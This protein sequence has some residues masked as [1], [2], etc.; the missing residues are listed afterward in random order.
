MASTADVSGALSWLSEVPRNSEGRME[1]TW[2]IEG[3]GSCGFLLWTTSL[4]LLRELEVRHATDGFW[5]GKKVL[6]LG[7]GMG[8]MAVGLARMG[9]HVTATEG[10][11]SGKLTAWTTKLLKERDGGGLPVP[12]MADGLPRLSAGGD[13]GG[14]LATTA[15]WWGAETDG[16]SDD[17]SEQFDVVILAEL[18]YDDDCHAALVETLGRALRP[19]AVAYVATPVPPV[20]LSRRERGSVCVGGGGCERGS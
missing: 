4:V 5:R 3:K 20:C 8:H 18:A 14:T 10:Q 1:H 17:F 13:L 6:E 11:V 2:D 7:A 19:G 15:L 16:L 12:S 9:A